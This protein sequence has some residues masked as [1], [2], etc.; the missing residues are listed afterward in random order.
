MARPSPTPEEGGEMSYAAQDWAWKV[1]VR[2]PHKLVLLALAYR[3]NSQTNQCN[4]SVAQIAEDLGRARTSVRTI[5]ASL[6]ILKD[7]GYITVHANYASKG[8]QTSNSYLM[9][10]GFI[11]EEV[12]VQ[13]SPRGSVVHPPI[14]E[15]P[16]R[17]AR[18]V[19]Q[20]VQ[21][22][23]GV[24][25]ESSTNKEKNSS[26]PTKKDYSLSHEEADRLPRTDRMNEELAQGPSANDFF[27]VMGRRVA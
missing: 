16:D 21:E 25:Q 18:A 11:H 22:S 8:Q 12:G 27:A 14:E 15:T 7:L 17:P 3:M 5:R 1:P 13:E 9:N 2:Y 4:P 10:I 26:S 20:G 6:E 24:V 19:V 23:T